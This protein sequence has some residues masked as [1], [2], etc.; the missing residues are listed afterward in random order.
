MKVKDIFV[1][2]KSGRW[3]KFALWATVVMAALHPPE[4]AVATTPDRPYFFASRE[5][6][7]VSGAFRKRDCAAAFANAEAELRD[8]APTF[9]TRA[10]CRLKF[11]YCEARQIRSEGEDAD[12]IAY[13]P[14]ALGV[15]MT[16]SARGVEAAPVL[17]VETPPS[18]FPPHPVS[19]EYL[20]RAR[21]SS[22][23]DALAYNAILPAHRFAPFPK[24]SAAGALAKFATPAPRAE[25]EPPVDIASHEETPEERRA[26]LKNAPFV[27]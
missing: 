24:N 2:A 1:A 12:S 16:A 27:E 6:C 26:R 18:L 9:A 17:A 10:D 3:G 23:D 15:E 25:E 5:A 20:A 14:L 4:R 7:V 8:L 19:R 13:S 22:E 11:H 21:E